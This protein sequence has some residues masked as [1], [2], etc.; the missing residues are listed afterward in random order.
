[1][2]L[3]NA[4]KSYTI[5][6][7]IHENSQNGIVCGIGK[8]PEK[9]ECFI[10][11]ISYGIFPD[12]KTRDKHLANAKTEAET[13]EKL[14]K[15]PAVT[16]KV[17]ALYDVCHNRSKGEFV[18][19]MEKMQGQTLRQWMDKHPAAKMDTKGFFARR[20][21]VLQICQIM[22]DI[23]KKYPSVVHR[24]LKPENIMVRLEEGR[25]T[26]SVVD[27]GCARLNFARKMGTD[28][29]WAPEQCDSYCNKLT[30]TYGAHT[31]IFAIGQIYYELLLG[32]NQRF[33]EHYV[34]DLKEKIWTKRPSLP[35]NLLK[36]PDGK[37]IDVLLKEMTEFNPDKRKN[38]YDGI[39]AMLKPGRRP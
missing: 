30:A 38:R 7:I 5:E 37:R 17:P 36:M 12:Q 19:V 31:D 13:L 27:F 39:L 14:A 35:E 1:M 34:A 4:T 23:N 25:W 2:S 21:I 26:V 6:T 11:R 16:G 9:G 20:M 15:I 32:E 18:I 3:N 33:N 28:G 10:K 24:D 22:S 8:H 29:Y